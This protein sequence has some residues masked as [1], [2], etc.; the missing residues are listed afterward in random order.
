[1]PVGCNHDDN[2]FIIM[3]LIHKTMLL[4]DATAPTPPRF[5]LEL[6]GVTRSCAG[7]LTYFLNQLNCLSIGLRLVFKQAYQILFCLFSI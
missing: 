7:M 2:H 5:P 4:R 6:F 3:N 1:M